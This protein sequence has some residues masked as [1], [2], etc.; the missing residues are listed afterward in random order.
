MTHEVSIQPTFIASVKEGFNYLDLISCKE[1]DPDDFSII[2]IEQIPTEK[3]ALTPAFRLKN[4]TIT[5]ICNAKC[6]FHISN[7]TYELDSHS[8]LYAKPNVFISASWKYVYDAYNISFSE[9]FYRK[10]SFISTSRLAF[11][12]LENA[13]VLELSKEEFQSIAYIFQK[14]SIEQGSG[15]SYKCFLIANLLTILIFEIQHVLVK[16]HFFLWRYLEKDS[17]VLNF[18]DNLDNIFS[19]L[20]WLTT[21]NIYAI[22]AKDYAAM[23]G[24][25][26]NYLS[27]RIK[28]LTGKTMSQ[29]ITLRLLNDIKYLLKLSSVPLKEIAGMYGFPE[30]SYFF[31]FF[32]RNTGFTPTKYRDQFKLTDCLPC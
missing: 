20:N 29:W 23:Q 28:L 16:K 19:K 32:K 12:K 15:S 5:L 2:K 26:V 10:Y 21:N 27:N 30:L 22:K 9:E 3:L 7:E 4:F 24:L 17:Q 11:L 31:T 25:H 13:K 8:L 14:L 18:I 1:I 6:S